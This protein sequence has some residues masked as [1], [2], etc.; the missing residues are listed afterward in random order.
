[1]GVPGILWSMRPS[2]WHRW[3]LQ[4]FS[5]FVALRKVTGGSA[6]SR[7]PW[8]LSHIL[9]VAAAAASSPCSVAAVSDPRIHP[10]A[11]SKTFASV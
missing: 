11:V 9:E 4:S 8:F 1:M 10:W 7:K 5:L 6:S 2:A 3:K